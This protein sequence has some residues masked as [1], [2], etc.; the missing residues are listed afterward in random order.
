MKQKNIQRYVFVVRQKSAQEAKKNKQMERDHH[1]INFK[2]NCLVWR[3][4]TQIRSCSGL[5]LIINVLV[6]YVKESYLWVFPEETK[7]KGLNGIRLFDLQSPSFSISFQ[8]LLN[9]SFTNTKSLQ[10]IFL[11]Y[12][13]EENDALDL[14]SCKSIHFY[15]FLLLF[16]CFF[17]L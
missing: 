15:L 4:V 8:S 16:Q 9:I 6:V 5:S 14:T 17:F 2:T 1:F 11:L 3:I 7:I 10:T 13:E 12:R